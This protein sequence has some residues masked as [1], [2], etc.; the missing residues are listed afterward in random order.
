[1]STLKRILRVHK[2]RAT[3]AIKAQVVSAFEAAR[4]SDWYLTDD[5]FPSEASIKIHSSKRYVEYDTFQ[6]D[7]FG[8]PIV[9][10]GHFRT[11]KGIALFYANEGRLS[12]IDHS[13]L[14]SIIVYT[15]DGITYT[16]RFSNTLSSKSARRVTRRLVKLICDLSCKYLLI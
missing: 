16:I 4:D 14:I 1:M 10:V 13:D 9:I 15:H 11:D 7:Q 5:M 6:R 2:V 3:H 12:S 8:I